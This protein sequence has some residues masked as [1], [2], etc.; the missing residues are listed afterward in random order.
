LNVL[1]LTRA[2]DLGGAERQLVVLAAALAR[3]GHTVRVGTF[4][5]GG[6]LE[7][8]LG[9][10]G[11]PVVDLGK[12]GRWDLAFTARLCSLVRETRP[13]VIHGYLVAANLVAT[14]VR[15]WARGARI[16]WGVRA[17]D[18]DLARYDGFQEATFQVAR[19]ASRCADVIV[20]NSRAGARFHVD[21]GYPAER[22]VVVPNGID[23]VRFRPRPERR[24]DVREELGL[25]PAAT[26]VGL[27]ARLDPMKDHG[28]F[29]AA[30]AL[31]ARRRP[32]VRFVAVGGGPPG[33]LDRWTSRAAAAGIDGVV[34]F[35]GPRLDPERVYAALDVATSTSAFGEGFPNAV[36]EAMACGVPCVVTDVGDAGDI[37]ARPDRV[38]PPGDATALARA[39]ERVIDE[40]TDEAEALRRSIEE[41]YSVAR[42]V[43]RTEAVLIPRGTREV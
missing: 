39:W 23:T 29:L 10:A 12:S 35:V 32:D 11:V 7:L 9:V 42:L 30:A 2:L 36:A 24:V 27:V 26:V 41:R 40:R 6:P 25:D 18:M 13:D 19:H 43:E 3:R 28:T 34:R 33:A 22:M 17:S 8:D 20:A 14:A 31:L 16:V 38:V 1:F 5:G 15:P 37:V 4:Y 21:R